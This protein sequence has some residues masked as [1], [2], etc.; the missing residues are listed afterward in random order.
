MRGSA[1]RAS[2]ET[3]SLSSSNGPQSPQP[4][5]DEPLEK[6]DVPLDENENLKEDEGQC[7]FVDHVHPNQ[8]PSERKEQGRKKSWTPIEF[9]SY[10]KEAN[11]GK[12]E[13]P[14]LPLEPTEIFKRKPRSPIKYVSDDK[15][16][17]QARVDKP[18]IP[19][20]SSE[21]LKKKGRTPSK[22]ICSDN[23]GDRGMVGE[24][25]LP[26]ESSEKFKRKPRVPIKF[27]ISDDEDRQDMADEPKVPL[28]PSEIFKKKPRTAVKFISPDNE[29]N[30]DNVDAGWNELRN[31]RDEEECKRYGLDKLGLSFNVDPTQQYGYHGFRR[32]L[33]AEQ[34]GIGRE[35]S[36]AVRKSIRDRSSLMIQNGVLRNIHGDR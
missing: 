23:K 18:A 2:L 21:K 35:W 32:K 8:V 12:V 11:Q 6:V 14:A 34:F 26:R 7:M 10:D 15:D 31:L 29:E 3:I 1:S 5:L 25:E 9:F 4:F 13:D 33:M 30:Q 27:V 28:A 17:M 16:D 20:E 24:P 36:D 22:F 19:L